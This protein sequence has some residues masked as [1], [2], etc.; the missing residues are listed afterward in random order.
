MN[1]IRF[2]SLHSRLRHV[3]SIPEV[4]IAV[5]I[6]VLLGAIPSA[7]KVRGNSG[8]FNGDGYADLCIGVPRFTVGTLT[9]A[10]GVNCLYGSAS[11]LQ[12]TGTPAAQLWTQA[13][14]GLNLSAASGDE[15][16]SSLAAG[17]FN[18]DGYDDLC[19]GSPF[20]SLSGMSTG[21]VTCMYGSKSG[22]Q[23]TGTGGP[24]PQFW[25]PQ[26]VGLIPQNSLL[27]GWAL[28]SGDFNHDGYDDLC[29]GA[30]GAILNG[31][32][33]AGQ[34][35]CIF[36]SPNGLTLGFLEW[37]QG[38]AGVGGVQSVNAFWGGTLVSADFNRDGYDDLCVGGYGEFVGSDE[39]AVN[40]LY[41]SANGLQ[42]NGT[43]GPAS[44][45]WHPG[46][47]SLKGGTGNGWD[48]F[49]TSMTVGDF[50]NDGYADL[51]IGSPQSGNP[52][53]PLAPGKV[54]VLYGSPTGLQDTGT[55]APD[56]QLWVRGGAVKGNTEGY[57]LGWSLT[58]GDFNH[59]GYDDLCIG[60][61]FDSSILPSGG[62]V[63]CIYGSSKGLQ[64]TGNGGLD[65]QLWNENTTGVP[66]VMKEADS[67]GTSLGSGDFNG[68]GYVD[69]AVG[70]PPKNAAHGSIDVLYGSSTGIQAAATGNSA[71][72]FWD[73]ASTGVPGS[74][75]GDFGYGLS[76]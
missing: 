18:N 32:V 70:D 37:D 42:A 38:S 36:G 20:R 51:A 54:N 17:D 1:L 45:Y 33:G 26:S 6:V 29:F 4:L 15:F 5:L 25:E 60:V 67:W 62:A 48:E 10:G 61:P 11:G 69:L 2:S 65:D 68:D 7:A 41:G 30:P 72:Q 64:A 27:F 24:K 47:N 40:C 3:V 14:V 44:Q 39:G 74:G 75:G 63:N 53:S 23:V 13:N 31:L 28:I 12:A 57:N 21:T 66:G 71:A 46:E 22:L 55:G 52:L 16:G 56:D 43:G 34:I 19:N 59:D 49:S 50:N 73:Q 76:H 58:A 9:T 35:V 8:D